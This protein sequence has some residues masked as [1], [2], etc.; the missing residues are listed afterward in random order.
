MKIVIES[1]EEPE[2]EIMTVDFNKIKFK[3]D[4]KKV[5]IYDWFSMSKLIKIIINKFQR[6]GI[7][8]F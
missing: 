2:I 3:I 7:G 4:G 6:F 1:R 8:G 5:T